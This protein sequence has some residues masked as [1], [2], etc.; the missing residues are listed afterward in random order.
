[1]KQQNR[2]LYFGM[3]VLFGIASAVVFRSTTDPGELTLPISVIDAHALAD[4]GSMEV[5]LRGAN[6]REISIFRKGSLEVARSQQPMYIVN[7][8]LGLFPIRRSVE[9]HSPPA[10]DARRLL[11]SWLQEKLTP[12][13][14]SKLL[15]NDEAA[16]REIPIDVVVVADLVHWIAE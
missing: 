4:G 5:R 10:E 9:R 16:L 14:R 8:V 3:V 15:V 13:Q 11:D 6:G 7:D 2:R 1:M 12:E